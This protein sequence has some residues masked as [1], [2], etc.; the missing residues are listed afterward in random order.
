MEAAD[1]LIQ[2]KHTIQ[3]T[4]A[5]DVFKAIYQDPFI[6]QALNDQDTFQ[7]VAEICGTDPYA[8]SPAQISLAASE[9]PLT[10]DQIKATPLEPFSAE[11]RQ[12]I[13]AFY[14][15]VLLNEGAISTLT[16]ALSVAL[17]MRERRRLTDSWKGLTKEITRNFS[18]GAFMENHWQTSLAILYGLV[19]DETGLFTELMHLN[20][21]LSTGE[22]SRLMLH[23]LILNYYQDQEILAQKTIELVNALPITDRSDA[24]DQLEKYGY[25]DLVEEV[26]Q[27]LTNDL[28]VDKGLHLNT[29]DSNLDPLEKSDIYER[30]STIQKQIKIIDYQKNTP[31]KEALMHEEENLL[32]QAQAILKR[33][34][35]SDKPQGA[36]VAEWKEIVDLVPDSDLARAQLAVALIRADETGQAVK[37]EMNSTYHPLVLA[38]KANLAAKQGNLVEAE[39]YLDHLVTA[40]L[41]YPNLTGSMA[42][43]IIELVSDLNLPEKVGRVFKALPSGLAVQD[44]VLRAMAQQLFKSKDY[45]RARQYAEA[46]LLLNDQDTASLRVLAKSYEKEGDDRTALSLWEKLSGQAK[47]ADNPDSRD[48]AAC[49]IRCGESAQAIET[50]QSILA[51]NPADGA[52]YILLGDAYQQTGQPELARDNYEKGVATSPELE[53]SWMKLANYHLAAGNNE[54]AMEILNTAI[55]AVPT[56]AGLH[57]SLGKLYA[58]DN[59][60]AEAIQQY[61]QANALDPQ[62]LDYVL[63]LGKSLTQTGLLNEAEDLLSHAVEKFPF[64]PDLL[65]QYAQVLVRQNKK[66]TAVVPYKALL[67]LHPQETAPYLEFASLVIEDLTGG[68]GV[69]VA[70]DNSRMELL[71]YARETLEAAL[72]ANPAVF[73][74]QLYLAEILA[75]LRDREQSRE[76]FAELSEHDYDLPADDRWRINYGLGMTSGEMGELDV[77]LAALQEA[78]NQ[79]PSHFQIHQQ[80]AEAYLRA[81]LGQSA[82]QAAQQALAIDPKDPDNLIWYA[83]FCT[84]SNELP[85][86]LSTLDAILKI[87]PDNID[88]RIKLGA[89][90]LQTGLVDQ[91]KTT[92]RKL[93]TENQLKSGHFQQIARHLADAGEYDEAISFLKTGIDTDPEYS[94]PLLLDLVQYE[95]KSGDISSALQTID[96]AI[97][98]DP[99][100]TRLKIVKADMQSFAED[101]HA[102][103]QTLEEVSEALAVEEEESTPDESAARPEYDLYLRLAYLYRRTG[104][105]QQSQAYSQKCLMVKE[106]DPEATF[107]LA[108]LAFNQLQYEK[109]IALLENV[110][111]ENENHQFNEMAGL[112]YAFAAVECGEPNAR[113]RVENLSLGSRWYLWKSALDVLTL[114]DSQLDLKAADAVRQ[115]LEGLSLADVQQLIP[116]LDKK[117]HL[118]PDLPVYNYHTY[119][120]TLYLLIA[121]AAARTGGFE[122]AQSLLDSI[123]DHYPY[124]ISPVFGMARVYTL[125]AESHRILE[126]ASVINHL[127]APDSL[128]LGSYETF[129]ELI[130]ATERISAAEIVEDWHKRGTVA[131]YPT[132][133]NINTML[134]RPAFTQSI[135]PMIWKLSLENKVGELQEFLDKNQAK[136]EV[137]CLAAILITEK[138]P[139]EALE[140]MQPVIDFLTIHP[141]FLAIFAKV[142]SNA[143]ILPPALDAIENALD[144]WND[145]PEWHLLAARISMQID[146]PKKALYH[147]RMAADL[148]PENFVIAMEMGD[149][150][151]KY[152]DFSQ[153]IASYRRAANLDP[154]N[155][156]P[157]HAMAKTYRE[158]SD[159][160]HAVSAIERAVTLAPDDPDPQ[161]LSAEFS[162]EAGKTADALKKIDTAL[163]MDPKN[164]AA[165]SLKSR[166]LFTSG[167][168][169]EA[170]DLI[171]NA[172]KKVPNPLPLLLTKADIIRDQEGSRAH[173]KALHEIAQ[174]YPKDT[175]VLQMYAEALAENNQ[176]SDA[177]HITQLALQNDPS[178]KD[179]HMLAGRILRASGQLDQAIDH[180]SACLNLDNQFIDAYLEMG[181][182]YQDRR[183]NKKATAMYQKAIEIA[184]QDHHAYYQ[185]GLLFRDSKDYRGA[186]TMLR[187][188]SELSKDDVNILRQLGAIIALNLV[189]TTQEVSVQS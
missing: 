38:V 20:G 173:L 65:H 122:T 100:N 28:Y 77:A 133:D 4:S 106:T 110:D 142:A 149:A 51:K 29:T 26:A 52:A 160:N 1:L 135:P 96:C 93:T 64:E 164:V 41:A 46:S 50:C 70:P 128:S 113:Q 58:L 78:A 152:K 76:L 154:V 166:A 158:A 116:A 35:I 138:A 92:F 7:K 14:Q 175:H 3:S 13:T 27:N 82:M 48:Y 126:K 84:R 145:E 45:R 37:I 10:L 97:G 8:W 144:L 25:T 125:Q 42:N 94:L 68:V 33:K 136:V 115:E 137:R 83:E 24:L 162:L 114:D 118:L 124:E 168:A 31:I 140:V 91:A 177:L 61:H 87:Q 169:Q 99:L 101:F 181:R 32:H 22:F 36:Y 174:D 49:A 187:K 102:A 30:L 67:D 189:H 5:A 40:L 178:L 103:I 69:P 176:A 88:L 74:I 17:A 132:I 131:F 109:S 107:M 186:E 112:L 139:N 23:I 159:L 80:L 16:E 147:L 183:D 117:T 150:L 21:Y 47:P 170:M 89:L 66:E 56:S 6:L 141:K 151:G 179:M 146:H 161:I 9:N 127:P 121:L 108:D 19:P 86:A 134:D 143:G 171:Q 129:E 163:R 104:A 39:L 157:W 81:N 15:K 90:Q 2:L 165:L 34:R 184:P 85:E 75:K 57:S 180:F 105:I 120:P 43:Q 59:A 153:A 148:Q 54:Q 156:S 11:I 111:W 167:Q 95:Q 172:L 71:E 63:A 188:A 123:R 72:D 12:Q 60:H 73:L 44:S 53:D 79:N 130:L 18:T 185:L 155:A 182:T 98:L 55:K 119:S 62:N